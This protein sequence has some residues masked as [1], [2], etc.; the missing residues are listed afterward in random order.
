MVAANPSDLRAVHGIT[1]IAGP[2]AGR[3]KKAGVVR[4]R[5]ELD[6]VLLELPYGAEARWPV[7]P[8]GSGHSLILSRPSY[9]EADPRAWAQSDRIGGSPGRGDGFGSE[10]L[11]G[12]VLN[13]FLANSDAPFKDFIE[14]YNPGTQAVNLSGAWLS[15]SLST[16]KYRIPEGIVLEPKSFAA[17]DETELGFAL[18]AAGGEIMFVNSNSTRVIDAIVYGPQSSNSSRGR[19]PDGSSEIRPLANTT[20]G[21]HNA[22][23]R[24][25]DVIINELMYHPISEQNGDEYVELHN[26]ES[27]EKDLSGWRLNDGIRFTF[28]PNTILPPK[29]PSGTTSTAC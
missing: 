14:L 21:A 22:E 3:L 19:P 4:L 28:P 20:P 23:V 29:R 16:N 17:W 15:D 12:V 24:R 13:E 2:Y 25:S 26:R 10:P 6:A 27:Q 1:N 7:A 5:N 8:N 9:G 18:R 11:R